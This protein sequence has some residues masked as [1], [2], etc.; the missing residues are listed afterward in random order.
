MRRVRKNL[1]NKPLKA[2]ADVPLEEALKA[3]EK[4][5]LGE[6]GILHGQDRYLAKAKLGDLVVPINELTPETKRK[7]EAKIGDLATKT[8]GQGGELSISHLITDGFCLAE[9]SDEESLLALA[10][11]AHS[12]SIYGDMPYSF[13]Q[14]RQ[15]IQTYL[16]GHPAHQ[17]F[18]VKHK[19]QIKGALA[20][21]LFQYPLSVGTFIEVSGFYV[22]PSH[23]N[24]TIV[25][26]FLRMLEVWASTLEANEIRFSALPIKR[27]NNCAI[28]LKRNGFSTNGINWTNSF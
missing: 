27:S 14:A 21:R 6:N 5:L 13:D 24:Y 15:T 10:K 12:G 16:T 2:K 19:G 25:R 26:K 7:L 17:I 22:E 4:N 8:A 1:I 9:H 23:R 11:Q 3:R 18:I 28:H 20:A